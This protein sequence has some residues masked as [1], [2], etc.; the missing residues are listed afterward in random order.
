MVTKAGPN[1]ISQDVFSLALKVLSVISDV[2][3]FASL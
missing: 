2:K 3:V 1:S